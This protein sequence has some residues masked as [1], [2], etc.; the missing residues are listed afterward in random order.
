MSVTV[1]HPLNFFVAF[2]NIKHQGSLSSVTS[3]P[4][5][6]QQ[7]IHKIA[8]AVRW[9]LIGQLCL[10]AHLSKYGNLYRQRATYKHA[11]N[12]RVSKSVLLSMLYVFIIILMEFF[13]HELSTIFTIYGIISVYIQ[14][15][16]FDRIFRSFSANN[17]NWVILHYMGPGSGV[18]PHI[19]MR[20][21]QQWQ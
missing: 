8:Q 3:P 7:V 1:R 10:D 20:Q 14:P 21:Y 13:N 9:I 4:A 11:I 18:F 15:R 6:Q 17:M 2:A 12:Q 16:Q 19:C 5:S